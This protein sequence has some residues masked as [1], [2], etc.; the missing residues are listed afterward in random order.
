MPLLNFSLQISGSSATAILVFFFDSSEFCSL[1]ACFLNINTVS[2]LHFALCSAPFITPS[3]Q[4]PLQL[5]CKPRSRST[6]AVATRL[7]RSI[8]LLSS[9][10][11]APF[12]C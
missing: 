11:T 8:M 4:Q 7:L 5:D 12:V 3:N 10:H 2:L 6:H 1:G 9:A